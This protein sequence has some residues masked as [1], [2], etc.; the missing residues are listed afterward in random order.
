LRLL[1]TVLNAGEVAAALAGGADIVDVKNPSE[2][3]LGAPAPSTISDVRSAVANRV[4]VSAALG[5]LPALPGSAALAALGAACAGACVVKVGLRDTPREEEAVELLRAMR[6]GL[7]AWPHVAIIAG[8]YADA[9][10]LNGAPLRPDRLPRVAAAAGIEGC[11]L[12]TAIKDGRGLFEWLS[13]PAVS[14][15]VTQAHAAG[16]GMALAGALTEKDIDL[17]RSA[18]ADIVGIRS[19]ACYGGLR[20]ARLDVRRVARIRA[21]CAAPPR[22][23]LIAGA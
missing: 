22:A 7:V 18:A 1:V 21:A 2:G 12:D 14:A 23:D 20:T 10:R 16:L 13:P 5:D 9:G 19:A 6:R 3:S 17:A 11:L 15:L 8:A 4:P